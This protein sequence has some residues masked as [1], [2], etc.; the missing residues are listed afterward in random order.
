LETLR[1][2][3]PTYDTYQR[4]EKTEIPKLDTDIKS[5]TAKL[6][7]ISKGMEQVS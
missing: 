3:L 4:I 5:L 1:A 7:E 6:T 2:L